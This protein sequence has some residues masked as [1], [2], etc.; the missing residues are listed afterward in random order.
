LLPKATAAAPKSTLNSK[1]AAATKGRDR[2]CHAAKGRQRRRSCSFA[3]PKHA[4]ATITTSTTT[5]SSSSSSSSSGEGKSGRPKDR[6]RHGR[7]AHKRPSSG[8][9][10]ASLLL[11]L[12]DGQVT[13]RCQVH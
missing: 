3:S 2:R 6:R 10:A 1:T 9:T 7:L 4:E 13:R 11:L 5:R 8:S 12:V